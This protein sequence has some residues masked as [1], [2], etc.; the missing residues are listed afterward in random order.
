MRSFLIT[1]GAG[2]FGLAFA[3]VKHA[4]AEIHVYSRDPLKHDRIT[5][6]FPDVICHVGSVTDPIRLRDVISRIRPRTVIHA[7]ALKHLGFG[8]TNPGEYV[9]VNTLGSENVARICAELGVEEAILISTDKAVEPVNVYGLSKALAERIWQDAAQRYPNTKFIT[10][11]FGNVMDARGSV[12]RAWIEAREAGKPITVR[13]PPPTRFVLSTGQVVRFTLLALN[14]G[15][16]GDVLVPMG[17]TSINIYDL[18]KVFC[19]EPRE[20][21]LLPGEK[22]HEMLISAWEDREVVDPCFFRVLGRTHTPLEPY[23]SEKAPKEDPWA[24]VYTKFRFLLGARN[25]ADS[26]DRN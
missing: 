13:V 22:Q 9:R 8:E 12:L 21:P 24:F 19:D 23:S 3:E 5:R 17:L 11:R 1:G 15:R 26:R 16:S 14:H 7:A 4:E 10:I 20:V 25:E 18:A 6:K 2:S